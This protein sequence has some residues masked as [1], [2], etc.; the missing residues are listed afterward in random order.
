MIGLS[1]WYETR[2]YDRAIFFTIDDY[3]LRFSAECMYRTFSRQTTYG[4][5]LRAEAIVERL[6]FKRWIKK[7]LFRGLILLPRVKIVALSPPWLVPGIQSFTSDWIDDIQLW[8]LPFLGLQPSPRTAVL[9]EQIK[10]SPEDRKIILALGRQDWQKGVSFFV[11]LA[12]D[13]DL[14]KRYKFVIVGQLRDI[15]SEDIAQFQSSGGMIFNEYLSEAELVDMYNVADLVW[16]CYHPIYNLNSGIFGR[17]VQLGKPTVVR[18]G[19]QLEKMQQRWGHGLTI[20]YGDVSSAVTSL[21]AWSESS[22]QNGNSALPEGVQR[23][24]RVFSS[25]S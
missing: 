12:Q 19:S 13:A 9:L 4:L 23:F 17:A 6:T 2:R 1:L 21:S 8:D 11:K 24:R 16:T 7:W 10:T 5:T 22:Q 15:A 3:I 20:I 18:K 25:R 14:R